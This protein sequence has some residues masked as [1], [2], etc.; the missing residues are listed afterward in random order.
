M[1]HSP[2]H[3]EVNT[4]SLENAWKILKNTTWKQTERDIDKIYNVSVLEFYQFF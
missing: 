1:K 4:S 3:P 2:E